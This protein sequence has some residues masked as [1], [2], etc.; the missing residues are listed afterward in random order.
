MVSLATPTTKD[1]RGVDPICTRDPACPLHDSS[2]DEVLGRGRPV[3]FLVA[4][5][6][7]CQVD[8]CGPV[9]DLLVD[10]GDT[11]GGVEMVHAEVYTDDTLESATEAVRAYKLPTEPVLYLAGADGTI[12]ERLDNIYDTTELAAALEK[13]VS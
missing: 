10:Q 4:T 1:P 5:P 7:Y 11:F 3:A 9:L 6:A 2:L 12:R 8:V 13:L